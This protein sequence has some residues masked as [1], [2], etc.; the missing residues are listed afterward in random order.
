MIVAAGGEGM[1]PQLRFYKTELLMVIFI[2]F[3][4]AGLNLPICRGLAFMFFQES[5]FKLLSKIHTFLYTGTHIHFF[6]EW[7]KNVSANHLFLF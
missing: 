2:Y 7:D 1:W 5:I 3:Y 6:L 4:Q